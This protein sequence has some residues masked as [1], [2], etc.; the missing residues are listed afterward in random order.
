MKQYNANNILNLA[1]AGHAGCGKTSVAE[2]M[3]YLAKA[4]DRLGSVTDGN[5]VLDYDAEEIKRQVSLM[6]AVAPLEWKNT[7]INIIDTPGL[8]DFE[9]GVAEGMRAADSAIVVVSGKDGIDVG[10]EKAVKAA[11]KQNLAKIFFVNGVCD[12]NARF[13][14]VFENLK[15]TFGPS[16]CPVVVPYIED[17][18]AEVYV[19]LFEYRAYK[20]TKGVAAP[21]DMP[22][23]GDRLEG[24]REA[25]NEAVAETSEEL[26]DKFLEGEEFT[27]E[28]IITGLSQ[29]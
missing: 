8:F 23:L 24:L 17:G 29:G 20:Y 15:A 9:G 16:V 4:S 5:T 21:T 7:K 26:L 28:E 27:P 25:I 2:S 10:T 14:D 6:T 12:E 3:L 19:N 11:K 1:F 22:A 13:Y 18:K